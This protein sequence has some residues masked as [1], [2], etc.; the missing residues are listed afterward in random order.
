MDIADGPPL[1]FLS[2][3]STLLLQLS[4]F[5]LP[6]PSHDN[7]G[8]WVPAN[9]RYS[10]QDEAGHTDQNTRIRKAGNYGGKF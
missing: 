3:K 10:R 9:D 1:V 2:N 6:A 7:G 4:S 5:H 8:A